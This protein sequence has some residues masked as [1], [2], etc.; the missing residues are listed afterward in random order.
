VLVGGGHTHVQVLRAWAMAP[1]PG[2]RVTVIL[3]RPVAVYSGMVPG[4]VAGQYRRQE[5]E[6]DVRPLAMRAGARCIVS[7]AARIDPREQGASGSMA[8]PRS[9]TTPRR[10]TWAPPWPGSTSPACAHAV[11]TRPIGRFVER[12]DDMIARA[13]AAGRARVVVV[14]AGAGGVEL[15]FAFHARLGREGVPCTIALLDAGARVLV[16]YP[17]GA[18]RRIERHAAARGIEIRCNTRVAEVRADALVLRAA[19]LPADHL[20][21]VAG[22]ASHSLFRDSGLPT[23]VHG[24]VR[25]RMTLQVEGH[26]ELFA[27]GDC[28][29]L[30]GSPVPKAGVYAVRQGPPLIQNLRARLAGGPPTVYWPQRDFLSLLNL[31]DGGA[32]ASK[33]GVSADGEWVFR[34]KDR[35]DRAFMERF[36][37][38]ADDGRIQPEFAALPEMASDM[39]CGGWRPGRRVGAEPRAGRLAPIDPARSSASPS[40]TTPPP[41]DAEGRIVVSTVDAFR[42]FT[43]DHWSAASP[44]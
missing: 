33:W 6:I 19:D 36:Q 17:E 44:R 18:V 16:G 40:P 24:F 21:W 12:V 9:R 4:F 28:A 37:V 20:V 26:D 1:V 11:P 35:I 3:D 34:L 30:I 13:R 38:L 41:S 15:A 7:A 2:V 32:V 14:G 31:G 39:I 27:V 5:L 23:D 22:A 8:A 43:D 42:A 29:S 25:T 10:S